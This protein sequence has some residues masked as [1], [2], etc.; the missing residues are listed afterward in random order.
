MT[1]KRKS[2]LLIISVFIIILFSA[3]FLTY[4]YINFRKNMHI[5]SHLIKA[6][7]SLEQTSSIL[8]EY[9]INGNQ[10]VYRQLMIRIEDFRN[11]TAFSELGVF[12]ENFS[13]IVPVISKQ[14]DLL[15]YLD[16]I[17]DLVEDSRQGDL[18]FEETL[19]QLFLLSHEMKMYIIDL[20]TQVGNR[21]EEETR[22]YSFSVY[23]SFLFVTLLV[24]MTV[25]WLRKGILQRLF[26]L[27][28]VS[29]S[30]AEGD[31]SA[32]IDVFGN[33]EISNLSKT[34]SVMQSSI[35]SHIKSIS[36][37][38][39]KL[40]V[41]LDSIGDGVIAVNRRKKIIL[42]NPVAEKLTGWSFEEAENRSI[43]SVFKI[44]NAATGEKA[45]SPIQKVLES[46]EVILLA[47]HTVLI[48]RTGEKYHIADSGSPIMDSSGK[49]SGVVIIF[50]D[51]TEKIHLE[52]MMIQSEKML[53]VGGL[54]AGMAHEINNPL[55]GIMQTAHVMNKRLTESIDKNVKAAE[56]AGTDMASIQRYMK[57]RDIYR[58]LDDINESGLRAAKIVE[59]MLGFARK[60]ESVV[61]SNNITGLI[62]STLELAGT[63]YDLKKR[64]DFRG[65]SIKKEY[66]KDLPPVPCDAG[67]IQQVLLN[68][69]RN[70]AQAMQEAGTESPSFI[71]RV[72][73]DEDEGQLYIEVEDNGPGMEEKTRK[74]VFEPFFTS[75]PVGEG[76]GLG[77]SVSYF[78]IK[79]NHGGDM[80][81]RSTPGKGA[82]F[83]ISLPL[84]H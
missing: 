66:E 84:K 26:R 18:I 59:N 73:R 21:V 64:Y 40:S 12:T 34:F 25:F 45:E 7:R 55:S 22:F 10:R 69:L 15:Y 58:M 28:Q 54:A 71:I 31:Y 36:A 68:I 47:N 3:C 1:L 81:V 56:K 19:S 61:S 4:G 41:V 78:I 13:F 24:I 32:S 60:S 63:D 53:S 43:S 23:G 48:S 2:F 52:E 5:E 72:Y 37:E 67:K 14:K 70:G 29:V 46:G 38:K 35:K 83:I 65:I 16:K 62:D 49:I 8:D 39:E 33:D 6:A 77:L 57:D 50:R 51:I 74:R 20:Y 80:Y 76:T 44:I 42:M 30:M 9:M 17:K 27:E 82:S 11:E 75:K 79:E